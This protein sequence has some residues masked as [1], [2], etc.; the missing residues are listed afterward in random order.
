MY[1]LQLPDNWELCIGLQSHVTRIATAAETKAA[2]QEC[3]DALVYYYNNFERLTAKELDRLSSLLFKWGNNLLRP[4]IVVKRCPVY[5]QISPE[6]R[7]WFEQLQ[8]MYNKR[9]EN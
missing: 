1:H 8:S 7:Q 2:E 4:R 6:F 9:T 3:S 5:K